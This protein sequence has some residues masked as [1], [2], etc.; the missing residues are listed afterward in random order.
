MAEELAQQAWFVRVRRSDATP[1]L[2]DF[3]VG[4]ATVQ[5][6]ILAILRQP[7]LD[8][9]DKV[10]LTTPLSRIE[11]ASYRLRSDEVRTY[12]RRIYLSGRW[13]VKRER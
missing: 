12:G 4:K 5:E 7:E 3:A 1:A 13:V 11:I 2:I 9:G 6:A 8:P 10:T